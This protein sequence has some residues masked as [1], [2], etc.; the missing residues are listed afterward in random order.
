MDLSGISSA[1][2]ILL[3]IETSEEKKARVTMCSFEAGRDKCLHPSPPPWKLCVSSAGVYLNV[4]I[5]VDDR[6]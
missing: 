1:A 3:G 2:E 6:I 4:C 5:D